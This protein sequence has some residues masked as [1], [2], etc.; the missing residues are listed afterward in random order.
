MSHFE[1]GAMDKTTRL[2][3]DPPSALRRTFYECPDCHRDVSV[4]K[5]EIRCPY[6]AHRPD[7]TNPCTYYNRNPSLDQRHKN[8][9]LKLKQFLERGE[10]I[11]I[12]R[13]C[14][15]GCVYIS[16]WGIRCKTATVKCEHRFEFNGSYKSADVAVLNEDGS[17]LCIFEVVHTHYTRELDRPEP[18][19]EIMADEINA[20]SADSKNVVLKCVREKIRP[21]CIARRATEQAARVKRLQEERLAREKEEQE[22]R[23]KIE[24]MNKVWEDRRRKQESIQ[25]AE[26][27]KRMEEERIRREKRAEEQRILR[28]KEEQLQRALEEKRRQDEQVRQMLFKK[29]AHDIPLCAK[30]SPLMSWL[31]ADNWVGRCNKC[32]KQISERIA[33]ELSKSTPTPSH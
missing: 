24:E 6:F 18:W 21:E 12:Q 17:I 3:V 15:C 11:T 26:Y 27:E 2:L 7:A 33:Q 9:Q 16:N 28:E 19:H 4:R 23:E 25:K 8:A 5:G 32:V 30:C 22:Q 10:E 29:H 20:L 31:K 1:H 13:K 14:P